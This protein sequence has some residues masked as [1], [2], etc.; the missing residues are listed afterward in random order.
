MKLQKNEFVD[1]LSLIGRNPNG[2]ADFFYE[3]VGERI[4]EFGHLFRNSNLELQK[5]EFIKGF[6]M[7]FSLFQNEKELVQFLK[8]LGTRHV[9]YEVRKEHYPPIREA[10]L[11]A[12]ENLHGSE[13]NPRLAENWRELVGVITSRMLE[14]SDSILSA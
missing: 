14:G 3:R 9:C 13:W 10:L 8:D 1:T 7:V 5:A 11:E 6:L 4:P 2:F 12:L